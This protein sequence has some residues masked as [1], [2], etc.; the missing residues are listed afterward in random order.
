MRRIPS[1]RCSSPTFINRSKRESFDFRWVKA[2][3]SEP[4]AVF[5][6]T[7]AS[8]CAPRRTFAEAQMSHVRCL[9]GL[10]PSFMFLTCRQPR[11]CRQTFP[12]PKMTAPAH[13]CQGQNCLTSH[14]VL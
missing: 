14:S 12:D 13:T 11:N 10:D 1:F 6:L 7:S 4:A 5:R 3:S 2:A 9:H 8:L